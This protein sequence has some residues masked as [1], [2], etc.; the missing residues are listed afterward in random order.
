M[1]LPINQTEWQFYTTS[2]DAWMGMLEAC[3][4]AQLS[5]DFEQFYF[6]PNSI[7]RE[8]IE[9]LIRKSKE[10]VKVRC[11]FDSVGSF[12]FSQSIYPDILEHTNVQVRFFNWLLPFSRGNKRLLYF[13]NHRRNLVVDK[14]I[15]F[16]G[17]V[18]ISDK[19]KD[20]RETHLKISGPVVEQMMTAFDSSW[21]KAHKRSIRF[22]KDTKTDIDGFT[23]STHAPL[24]R[25]R[26]L[27]YR[28]IDAIRQA[29][30]YIYLSTPYFLP[31]NR[32]LRVLI[33]AKRR[34]V[35]VRLLVP[36]ESNHPIVDIGGRTYFHQLLIS[37]I[38]IFRY[39]GMNHA[40]TAVI[41]GDWS[42]VGSLNLDNVS[43]RY[44][45]EA[46]IVSTNKKFASQL[47]RQFLIDIINSYELISE[48]WQKRSVLKK[49][50]E[51]VVWPIRKFL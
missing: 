46:A 22:S 41:D 36:H 2:K 47:E 27:Y 39:K 45:F 33:L 29:Q 44:N 3:R 43:L 35:D 40:K 15:A 26:F 5:I 14:K 25:Q 50:W 4:S 17:G 42:M 51:A 18:C 49:F 30:R 32:L 7:A 23:Y 11:L 48:D 6:I 28:L 24:P 38:R 31:D 13:R 10:G 20:W 12:P 16:T 21:A 34:G 9:V 37:G 1:G 19:M 8:F